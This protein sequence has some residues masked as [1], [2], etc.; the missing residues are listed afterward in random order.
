MTNSDLKSAFFIKQVFQL[1]LQFLLIEYSVIRD[2]INVIEE[3]D[4]E[5]ELRRLKNKETQL[6]A[7]NI[8]LVA[9][10]QDKR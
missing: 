10:K 1:L 8:A 2:S 7:V 9:R 4:S 6:K 5:I 3:I